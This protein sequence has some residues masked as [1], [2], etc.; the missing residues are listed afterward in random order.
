[1]KIGRSA[2]MQ[3]WYP[4]ARSLSLAGGPCPAFPGSASWNPLPLHCWHSRHV[5]SKLMRERAEPAACSRSTCGP[6]SSVGPATSRGVGDDFAGT[7]RF[8][9][10]PT[11]HKGHSTHQPPCESSPKRQPACCKMSL[12]PAGEAQGTRVKRL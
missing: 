12:A 6:G 8:K 10:N 1:M 9:T 7:H 11:A 3:R 4:C 2:C 5:M